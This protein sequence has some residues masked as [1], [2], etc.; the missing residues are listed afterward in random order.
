MKIISTKSKENRSRICRVRFLQETA[1]GLIQTYRN[2]FLQPGLNTADYIQLS[3]SDFS[4]NQ[5]AHKLFK[6][7]IDPSGPRC[8]PPTPRFLSVVHDGS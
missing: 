3:P 1:R 7:L 6:I 5:M 2:A 4:H 8:F